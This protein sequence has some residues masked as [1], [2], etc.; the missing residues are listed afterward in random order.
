MAFEQN[1]GHVQTSLV[2]DGLRP[3]C[4]CAPPS[5]LL[6]DHHISYV[7]PV[8]DSS[9]GITH[10]VLVLAPPHILFV[11]QYAPPQLVYQ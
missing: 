6:V 8:A 11:Y 7:R 9:L 1:R 3:E 4:I 5:Q 10:G 2:S